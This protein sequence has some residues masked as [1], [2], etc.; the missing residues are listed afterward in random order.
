MV[1]RLQQHQIDWK[2]LKLSLPSQQCKLLV[3]KRTLGYGEKVKDWTISIQATVY[4]G[5]FR[6]QTVLGESL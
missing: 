1:H 4:G 5:R 6:D 3:A 2:L